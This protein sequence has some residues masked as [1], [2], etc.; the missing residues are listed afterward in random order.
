M[1]IFHY[2]LEL[3]M[4]VFNI[5]M[6]CKITYHEGDIPWS[7]NSHLPPIN[8]SYLRVK[9]IGSLKELA[10]NNVPYFLLLRS[11]IYEYQPC[12]NIYFR[13]QTYDSMKNQNSKGSWA[14][15]FTYLRHNFFI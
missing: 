11:T 7:S 6:M 10:I 14:V 15:L 3:F 1:Q 2:G 8:C 9:N 5:N 4:F 12:V 13:L